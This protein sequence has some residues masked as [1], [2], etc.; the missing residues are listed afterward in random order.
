MWVY[1][2]VLTALIINAILLMF[3]LLF[4]RNGRDIITRLWVD[5]DEAVTGKFQKFANQ[6][7]GGDLDKRQSR[8]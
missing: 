4:V 8:Y 1:Y 5:E 6:L 3:L 2:R 7:V